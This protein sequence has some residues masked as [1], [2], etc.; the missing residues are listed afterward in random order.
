MGLQ[1]PHRL[2]TQVSQ[3]G[4]IRKLALI[5]GRGAAGSGAAERQPG[6]GRASDVRPCTYACIDTAEVFGLAGGGVHEG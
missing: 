3:E 5:F 2:D 4:H 1:V 6:M